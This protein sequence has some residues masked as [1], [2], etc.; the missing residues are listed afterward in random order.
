MAAQ[1]P[2]RKTGKAVKRGKSAVARKTSKTAKKAVKPKKAGTARKA[3][4]T[5]AVK[6]KK[7][8]AARK[9][10]KRVTASK[11]V[12]ATTRRVSL[13]QAQPALSVKQLDIAH[14]APLLHQKFQIRPEGE[15]ALQ[16]ELIDVDT[17]S[18]KSPYAPSGARR[19]AFSV[20]F[21]SQDT[22]HMLPQ[23]I[24]TVKHRRL[25]TFD[26]FLVPIGPDERG[27]RY[28]AVFS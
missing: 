1:S 3:A 28:E 18:E 11:T 2:T 8:A 13:K 9:T 25:G 4:T 23:K 19:H 27:M 20:T 10:T 15:T 5:K 6:P 26:L 24:Y 7:I 16:M 21:R 12:K 17:L 22:E 14:F